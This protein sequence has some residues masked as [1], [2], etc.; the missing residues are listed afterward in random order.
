MN[1]GSKSPRRRGNA[2][3]GFAIADAV[4]AM[5]LLT[6]AIGGLAGSVAYGLRLHRTNREAAIAEQAARAI[7]ADLRSVPFE[8]VFATFAADP[9]IEVE[10]LNPRPDDA[11][12]MVAELVFPTTEMGGPLQLHEDADIPAL[13]C[14]R[15]LDGQDGI[16]AGDQSGEYI[17]L[18]V[19][20]RLEWRGAGGDASQTYHAML[21]Q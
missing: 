10:G 5:L 3:Q 13:G 1:I 11:D 6:V 16:E 18:P 17:I 8:D 21:T 7:L 14:P 20:L 2:R 12:G 4:V 19:L 9:D 15:D